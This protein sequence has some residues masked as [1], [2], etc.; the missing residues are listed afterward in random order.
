M[1]GIDAEVLPTHYSM[2]GT[3]KE[4]TV[5]WTDG[6]LRIMMRRRQQMSTAL[7][8]RPLAQRHRVALNGNTNH[9]A[10]TG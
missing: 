8:E 2:I 7:L 5:M 10:A 4:V 9:H 3:Q 1:A 6:N